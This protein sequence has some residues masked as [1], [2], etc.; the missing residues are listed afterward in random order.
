MEIV[1]ASKGHFRAQQTVVDLGRL[2]M[3]RI[4]ENLPRIA[5][6]SPS[7]QRAPILFHAHGNQVPTRHNGH[8]VSAGEI[9][10]LGDGVLDHLWSEGPCSTAAM[11]L[12]PEDLAAAGTSIVG[13]E[14]NVPRYTHLIRPAPAALARLRALHDSVM[15]LAKAGPSVLSHPA[16][17]KAIEHELIWTMVSCLAGHMPA[18]VKPT[19]RRHARVIASFEEFLRQRRYEPLYLADICAGIGVSG[20]LLHLCCQEH[21]GTSPIRYLWLR[22]MHLVRRALLQ[23]NPG[24]ASVTGI[25][26][27]HGFW[28]LGRFSGQ[29]RTLFGESPKATLRRQLADR[30]GRSEMRTIDADSTRRRTAE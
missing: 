18:E 6:A 3:Q 11:S 19:G 25:A 13:Q 14:L 21:F 5:R 4:D 28:E 8:D 15:D 7:L 22:R 23:A 26:V 16:M 2:W 10:V 27:E 9:V 12:S 1:V 20:R 24:E 17:A 30:A 29:Y